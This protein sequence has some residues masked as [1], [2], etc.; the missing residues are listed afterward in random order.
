MEDQS[1][2]RRRRVD[3][4]L[5]GP[6]LNA[7]ILQL[8]ELINEVANRPTQS[9]EPPDHQGVPGAQLVQELVE[10]GAGL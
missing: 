9:V 5:Q 1:A 2:A 6:K 8:G 7:T 4:F 10:F 3:V